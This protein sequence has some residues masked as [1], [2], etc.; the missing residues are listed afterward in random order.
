M[1]A[2]RHVLIGDAESPHLLKW[3]RTLS[4][5]EGLE[6]WVV[7]SRGFLAEFDACVLPERRLALNVDTVYAGGNAAILRCLPRLGRWLRKVDADWLHPHYLTSHGTLAWL[8]RRAFGLRALIAGSAWGSDILLTPARSWI[9]RCLTRRV[10]KACSVTTSD[11]AH[12]A[13][14]MVELGACEVMTFPFGLDALPPQSATKRPWLFFANRALEPL[15]RPHRALQQFAAIAEMQ[16]E[17]ELV[18]AHDGSLRKD[19]EGQA[20]RLACG[21]RIHFVGRLDATTQAGWYQRA[22]W[23]FSLPETDSVSVSVIEA[24]AHG[25]IPILSDLPANRELVRHGDNGWILHEEERLSMQ[26]LTALLGRSIAI[27]R[28]NRDWVAEHA[29]FGPCVERFVERLREIGP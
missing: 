5:I 18:V 28:A 1:K 12:M 7:S 29:L 17:A 14:R 2:L 19:L 13:Q 22:Q 15:Y 6:L 9:Y 26:T 24:M 4:A 23:Y 16:A 21:D 20:R 11:S 27:S 8:A 3:A 25:A 10:L